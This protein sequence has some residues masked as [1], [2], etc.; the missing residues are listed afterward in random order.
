MAVI[1]SE[2][3]DAPGGETFGDHVQTY[4]TFVKLTFVFVG[5]PGANDLFPHLASGMRRSRPS[6]SIGAEAA[7]AVFV[8]GNWPCG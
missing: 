2:N 8:D 6:P 5:H 3:I 7:S 1:T 4:R